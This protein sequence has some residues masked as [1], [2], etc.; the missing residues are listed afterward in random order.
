MAGMS[1][2]Q[3]AV[4]S[5]VGHGGVS[6]RLKINTLVGAL[7]VI[8]VAALLALELRS[9]QASVHEEVVAANRVAAQLLDRTAWLQAAQGAPAMRDF[10][11]GLGRLRANDVALFDSQGQLLYRSPPSPY[12]AGRDAPQWFT[13]LIAPPPTSR[14]IQ[15]PDGRLEV[16]ANASR[17]VLDAWDELRPQGV[18]ALALLLVVNAGV[19][20]L[21]GHA[22][23][24]L[25]RI[26]QA[27]DT[28]QAG[29]LDVRLPSLPGREAAAIGHAFNRMAAQLGEHID[30][31]RR[32]ARAEAQLSD[33]RALRRAIEQHIEAERRL[34]AREL[35]DELGQSVTAVR[36]MALSIAGRHAERHDRIDADTARAA[37]CIADEAARLYDAM[38]GMIPRLAPLVLDDFGLRDALADLAERTRRSHPALALT[39]VLD[40]RGAKPGADAALTLYRAAQEGLTNA[41]RHGR[42]SAVEVTLRRGDACADAPLAVDQAQPPPAATAKTDGLWLEV[43]DNGHGLSAATATAAEAEASADRAHFGLR[44]LG[45]RAAALGGRLHLANAAPRGARLRVW[46]PL[47]AV[48]EP[49][50]NAA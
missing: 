45:E 38:H 31:E 4:G 2:M 30:T 11:Q 39:L 48:A 49:E 22:T 34:I 37:Q 41:L 27:L 35:H 44:W 33:S 24:P 23:R 20:A 18:G 13:R 47:P 43:R 8:F 32:A 26:A 1:G 36:S 6:L 29:R 15:F 10:L 42:A 5:R 16:H 3:P 50:G 46:L 19:F 17:A 14:A 9:M 25:A 12:K 28:L 40:L 21:V 7:T